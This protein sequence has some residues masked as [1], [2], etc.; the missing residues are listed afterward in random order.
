MANVIQ[1]DESSIQETIQDGVTLVD[2][3]APWCGPCKMQ[4]PILEAVSANA[5]EGVK[6]AKVNID[7]NP[8]V[9]VQFGFQ[10]IPTL[11]VFKD[12]QEVKR[13][14]TVTQEKALLEAVNNA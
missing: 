10:S 1:L 2:F 14:S 12:G 3:W 4:L 6:V 9:A 5:G 8:N 7:E 11:I 13:F